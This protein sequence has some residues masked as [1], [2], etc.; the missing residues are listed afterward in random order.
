MHDVEEYAQRRPQSEY[1]L[2]PG[3]IAVESEHPDWRIVQSIQHIRAR[4]PVIQ[5]LRNTEVSGVED[6]AERPARQ[7]HVSK[8]Q[9]VFAQ[10]VRSR[11]LLAELRHAP[12]VCEIVEKG[13]DDAEGLLN[14]HEAVE[15]PLAVELVYGLHVRRVAGEALRGHDVLT[16]VV[17]FGGTIPEEEAA[18]ESW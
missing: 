14:A 3:L 5:L 15:G 16:G 17:A 4:R 7:A 13:E 1:A 18:V 10:G 12:V 9:I 2:F 8:P 6:H 11:D